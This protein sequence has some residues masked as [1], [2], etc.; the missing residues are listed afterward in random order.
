MRALFWWDK[1]GDTSVPGVGGV[2]A[3]FPGGMSREGHM[4]L[5]E[6]K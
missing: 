2:R 1:W 3:Y 5:V 4:F 6:D